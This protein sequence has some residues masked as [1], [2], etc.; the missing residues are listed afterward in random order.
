MLR[1]FNVNRQEKEREEGW[2][3]NFEHMRQIIIVE[4]YD[5][6][7]DLRGIRED[8][9]PDTQLLINVRNK[10]E[11]IRKYVGGQD[12]KIVLDRRS[13]RWT[14]KELSDKILEMSNFL[15]KPSTSAQMQYTCAMLY[16][17]VN[18]ISKARVVDITDSPPGGEGGA[19]GGVH[20]SRPG[21]VDDTIFD[22]EKPDK[23]SGKLD[24][25]ARQLSR[26]IDKAE[27]GTKPRL[28][29]SEGDLLRARNSAVNIETRLEALEQENKTFQECSICLTNI[30]DHALQC[31]HRFCKPCI[32]MFRGL[33]QRCPVC[34]QVIRSCIRLY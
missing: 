12:T 1:N 7:Y 16:Q 4:L 14:C 18:I 26:V 33:P 11:D 15:N 8:N 21:E 6:I 29:S 23:L 32:E 20:G 27:P 17:L 5:L 34:K 28:M 13:R 2:G 9:T 22:E 3:P 10:L 19:P 31:G 25:F 24:L 30:P